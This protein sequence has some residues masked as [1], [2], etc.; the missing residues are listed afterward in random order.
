MLSL[1]GLCLAYESE[2]QP[3]RLAD[4]VELFSSAEF[5][6]GRLPADSPVQVEFRV[7]ANGGAG[8]SMDGEGTLTWPQAL[9]L[10][11]TGEPG[12][13]VLVLDASLDAVTEVTI[14]LSDYGYEGTF[15]I[16]R[17]SLAMDAG[18]FFDPFVL[19]GGAPDRVD[20]TDTLGTL[21]LISYSYPVFDIVYLNFDATMTPK[22]T[23][24][25]TGVQWDVNEARIV[26]EDAAV[27]LA[28]TA[29]ADFLVDGVYLAAWNSDISL[30]FTPT[31]SV[32][33][34]FIGDIVIASF[35]I[36]VSLLRE[37]FEDPFPEE[38]YAFPM[39]LLAVGIDQGTFAD[40]QVGTLATL[41]VPLENQGN[42]LLQGMARIEGA[43]DFTVYPDHFS[44]VPAT[45]DGL[46]ISFTP[47]TAEPQEATLVLE[48]NDPAQPA[49][50][51]P[52][53][54]N[55]VEPTDDGGQVVDQLHGSTSA[56]GCGM[57]APGA[58]APLVLAALAAG[59]G[60]RRRRGTISR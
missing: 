30:V 32:T 46:V 11:F 14:D 41:N 15:E 21:P 38:V 58:G 53:S 54:G 35:D 56:C 3:V 50:R 22:I 26:A 1:V 37:A 59:A 12:S 28:P 49:V 16:D 20:V 18:T 17:R 23:V 7:E 44:A 8:A 51:I 13:G 9:T 27:A 4:E 10:Q 57:A 29:T 45:T 42:L 39:P 40:V 60:A 48:S 47:T 31:I 6:T 25:F 43:S 5:T 55:G 19:D 52:I 36:P 33:A 24:G 2:P 34:P